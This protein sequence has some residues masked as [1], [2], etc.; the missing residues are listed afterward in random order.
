MFNTVETARR[1]KEARLAQNMTQMALADAMG[2]SFQAVSNWERGSSMPDIG[3]L[4]QLCE[5]LKISL[6]DLLGEDRQET[7]IIDKLISKEPVTV[8]E[9]AQVTPLAPPEVVEKTVQDA[10]KN[11]K[12]VAACDIVCLAPFLNAE[13]LSRL[14][15]K[16]ADVSPKDLVALAPFLCGGTLDALVDRHDN[17]DESTILSLAPF[18]GRE[19][20][21]QLAENY[22]KHDPSRLPALAPFLSRETLDGIVS[23]MLENGSFSMDRLI[24]LAPFLAEDTLNG[25]LRFLQDSDSFSMQNMVALAPFLSRETLHVLAEK[26]EKRE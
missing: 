26:W 1:I 2:I 7:K 6:S 24:P 25:I 8:S 23:R 15:E 10:E 12:P 13:C 5:V 19:K 17:L 4:S 11:D 16:A 22:E 9:I 3:K 18:L 21:D 20:L 14:A